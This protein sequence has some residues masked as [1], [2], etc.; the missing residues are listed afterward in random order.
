[1]TSPSPTNI[2]YNGNITTWWI[3]ATNLSA[4]TAT[5][6]VSTLSIL[7]INGLKVIT[8][9]TANGTFNKTTGVWSIGT[10]A[11]GAT[12]WLKLVTEVIDIGLAPFILTY[13]LSGT[14]IDPNNV[15]NTGTQTLTSVVGAAV[16]AAIDDPN[17]CNCVDVSVNDTP[18]N[19]GVTEWRLS[20]PS[21]TNIASYTWDV[22]TGK[23]KIIPTTPFA[24]STFTYTM[25]C[26]TGSG[27]VQTAGPATV[28][29]TA[30]FDSLTPWNHKSDIVEYSELSPTDIAFIE[31]IPKYTAITLA[32]YCWRTLRNASDVLVGAEAIE[33]TGQQDTR[34]FYFCSEDTCD[35]TPPIC[36]SCPGNQLPADAIT[37]INGIAN[38]TPEIGD[39][40]MV[41]FV[42]SYAYYT[43]ETLG[44]TRS[45]CGCVYKIS[46]NAGN[47][48]ALG[49][50]NAP[51]LSADII[52]DATDEKARV[53]S[54]DTTSGYLQGKLGAGAGIAMT[55]LNEGLNETLVISA[56]AAPSSNVQVL[57]TCSV[58]MG[59][60]GTGTA[61]D[62]FIISANYNDGNP[63]PNIVSISA[64]VTGITVDVSTLWG[65]ACAAGCTSTYTL[66]TY[67][68]NVYDNVT[69]IGTTLTYDILAD[70]PSGTHP[71]IIERDCTNV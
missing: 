12:V 59:I 48:L 3:P 57:D 35:P 55:V 52:L 37:Y 51:Y 28:T 69:L 42:D 66:I 64:G 8:W 29:I 43:Y 56:S 10:L 17:Q 53:S 23:G 30:M 67:P 70:A 27:F 9:E 25:W 4:L 7:P 20:V 36:P 47:I 18:C 24:N 14:N 16:A 61:P 68:D 46:K 41:Q 2:A 22:T 71:F 13:V 15:N 5:G 45:G 1:M 6:V 40:I 63:T 62:P 11:P 50:D 65:D 26:N 33:C 34:H 44:W 38:Y 39:T 54:N 21:F 60:T 58:N 31:T 49:T 32:D 19:V